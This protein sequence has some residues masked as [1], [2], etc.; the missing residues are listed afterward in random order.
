MTVKEFQE[1]CLAYLAEQTGIH[2]SAW[3]RWFRGRPISERVLNKAAEA[4]GMTP[5]QLLEGIR[6]RRLDK[7]VNSDSK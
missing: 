7:C 2:M 6:L 5:L 1:A 3:S 4:L